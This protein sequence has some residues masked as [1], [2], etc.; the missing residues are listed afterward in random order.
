MSQ[1]KRLSELQ[2][3]PRSKLE[4]YLPQGITLVRVD[5]AG[6]NAMVP[7][8]RKE[9][10]WPFYEPM[11]DGEKSLNLGASPCLIV[12][13]IS[14]KM[15]RKD[16]GHFNVVAVSKYS[17]L[18]EKSDYS[19]YSSML[20]LVKKLRQEDPQ[21]IVVLLGQ[22][23]SPLDMRIPPILIDEWQKK[24]TQVSNDLLAAGLGEENIVDLRDPTGGGS[25]AVYDS[26]VKTIYYTIYP[27][28]PLYSTVAP[29]ESQE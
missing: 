4:V 8:D 27:P 23:L 22:H 18:K 10:R 28:T 5:P 24:R 29:L 17:G 19:V 26:Q 20:D 25:S 12:Y 14:D 15:N 9:G 3:Q 2:L 16:Q 6:L 21:L 7:E 1:E 13:V 11:K